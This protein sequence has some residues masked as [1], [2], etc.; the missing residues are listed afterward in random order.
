MKEAARIVERFAREERL[1]RRVKRLLV[2]VSGGSDSVAAL[3]VLRELRERFGFELAVAHFDHKLRPDSHDDLEF[4]RQLCA[5]LD[6]PCFTGEGDVREAQAQR[7]MG[8]EEAAR[9]MR[10]QF[11]AFI[12]GKQEA[13]A[14]AT[15]HTADDQAETVLQRVLRGSGVRGIRGMLPRSPVP[16]SE[17][18]T[19]IRPLLPLTR[20][21]TVGICQAAGVTPRVDA[22]NVDQSH[23][24]NRLRHETLPYLRELNPSVDRALIGLAE[25]A[26]ELFEDVENRAMQ[27]QPRTRNPFGSIFDVA[28]L[29]A[30]PQEGL[31]LVVEREALFSRIEAEINRTRLKNLADVLDKGSGMVAFGDTV[32]EVSSGQA[33]IGPLLQEPEPFEPKVLNIPGVTRAGPWRIEV[34]TDRLEPQAGETVAAIPMSSLKGAARVRPP[35]AGDQLRARK[36]RPRLS[37]VFTNAKVPRWERQ[38]S[39]VVAD[40]AGVITVSHPDIRLPRVPEDDALWIRFA[41]EP[42]G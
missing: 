35:Q 12:A 22:S 10:Y 2:A 15:G 39:V 26:R 6:V 16:G 1:F 23:L 29:A 7:R 37:D 32:V 24:R 36:G 4:V 11:L 27:V 41:F 31:T 18:H 9:R 3:L 42:P 5:D 20:A 21:D 33:R 28:K 34:S 40:S 17:A 8:M 25:S 19:L 14:I 13:G 38:R 30:L